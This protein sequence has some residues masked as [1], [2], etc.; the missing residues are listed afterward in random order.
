MSGRTWTDY[1]ALLKV[2]GDKSRPRLTYL[3]G[4]VELMSLSRDHEGIGWLLSRL[5][6]TYMLE[7]G[8][9]FRG[10]GSSTFKVA[11][12]AGLEPDSC[13][14][15]GSGNALADRPDLALEVHWTNGGLDKLSIYRNLLVPE[16]WVW[17]DYMIDVHVLTEQGYEVRSRSTLL[18]DLDV[19]LLLRYLDRPGSSETLVTFRTE[20][21]RVTRSPKR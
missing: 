6:E 14:L 4:A 7:A 11:G 9:T 8:V 3:D 1:E 19:N 21:S 2:R 16:V 12:Q 5:L 15:V 10:L 18:P 17:R 20:V 13:W